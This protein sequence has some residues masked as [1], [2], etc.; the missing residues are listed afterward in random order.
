MALNF[1]I[2]L[3]VGLGAGCL[4]HYFDI[5]KQKGLLVYIVVGVLSGF[6]S[7]FI[8][9]FTLW[10]VPYG[11]INYVAFILEAFLVYYFLRLIDYYFHL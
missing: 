9:H 1:I 5:N 10:N 7:A 4:G 2:W 6:G 8:I 3:V 11:Q